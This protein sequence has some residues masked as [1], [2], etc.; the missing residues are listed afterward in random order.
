[1]TSFYKLYFTKM[2]VGALALCISRVICNVFPQWI[3][4]FTRP[5]RLRNDVAQHYNEF[6]Y[7]TQ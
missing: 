3:G 5:K 6:L 1:M 7:S 4:H 2:L